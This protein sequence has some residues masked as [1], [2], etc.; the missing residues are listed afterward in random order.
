MTLLTDE[1]II[2][3]M[4]H[5]DRALNKMAEN[6][7][8]LD[9]T[10]LTSLWNKYKTKIEQFSHSAEWEKAVIIFSIINA[11]REKNAV[12]NEFLLNQNVACKA[13]RPLAKEKTHLI[14]G[15]VDIQ[16]KI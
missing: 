7:L 6:I 1:D 5:L 4:N 16:I 11:V 13:K 14:L 15:S 3:V 9:E 2:F 8:H 12:I 10:S